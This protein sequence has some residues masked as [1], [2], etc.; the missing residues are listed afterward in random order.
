MDILDKTK[1]FYKKSRLNKGVILNTD[2]KNKIYYFEVFKSLRPR[3][4]VQYCIHAREYITSYLALKQILRFSRVGKKG[5][6]IFIP[7]LNP[8]GVAVCLN[9]KPNYK[10][11]LSGVDLNVNFDAKWGTGEKNVHIP[12]DENYVG[13]CPF[14]EKETLAL[15]DFT[16]KF[17]PDF[18]IS[19]HSKG[20]EIY[21][22]FNQDEVVKKRDLRFA[23]IVKR[24]T[25][26]K[27]VEGLKSAGGFKDW[28]IDKLKI[29][30]LTIEVGKDALTHPIGKSNLSKI[31]KKN[32][33]VI[34]AITE[35]KLWKNL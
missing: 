6:V 27:I 22:D 1:N 9:G 10:A 23:N 12:G 29:P 2:G 28:C 31:Y 25:G 35:S 30:S 17:N 21:Y 14:S 7:I 5:H 8:D 26:Y 16:L 18:T 34:T 20:E 19:Y 24:V 32:K 15:K 4:I 13:R 11:N 3:L 33:N